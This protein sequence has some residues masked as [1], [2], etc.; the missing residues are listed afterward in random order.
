MAAQAAVDAV[1]LDA[2]VTPGPWAVSILTPVLVTTADAGDGMVRNVAIMQRHG[3]GL[4]SRDVEAMANA[5]LVAA[6]PDHALIAWG[7][8]VAA[9]RWEPWGDGRGEFCI[10]G[11]R[12]ATALDAFGV[13]EMTAPLREALKRARGF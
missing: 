10:N 11:V 9:G 7:L 2:S 1:T 12:F 3:N 8:C 13:P 4:S 5:R 6:A